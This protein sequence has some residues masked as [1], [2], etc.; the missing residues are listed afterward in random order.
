MQ[1][2]RDIVRKSISLDRDVAE[3]AERCAEAQR[4]T[5]STLVNRTLA[6]A[7]NSGGRL[8]DDMPDEAGE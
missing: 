6:M 7:T 5:F 8:P 2:K 4:L 3:R 1:R